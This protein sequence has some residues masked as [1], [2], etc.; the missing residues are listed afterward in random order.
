MESSWKLILLWA[1]LFCFGES[2]IAFHLAPL[3]SR[4]E[5][6]RE[7][8]NCNILAKV[9]RTFSALS[10][11]CRSQNKIFM[12]QKTQA[13]TKT[14][15]WSEL[16]SLLPSEP[17]RPTAKLTFYRDTNG[18]C[19]FCERVWIAL[20]YKEIEYDPVKI[21]LRD[22]PQWY[23]DIVPTTLVPA[24]EIHDDGW[25][26]EIR[27]SGKLIWESVDILNALDDLFP[28]TSKIR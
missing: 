18:W 4:P 8:S 21:E 1:T 22:K 24:I 17:E 25:K 23:K 9:P 15:S 3:G 20:D 26:P 27:G 16:E 19:P 6:F 11:R 13:V 5:S 2:L 28:N 12:L 10:L 14:I 7:M